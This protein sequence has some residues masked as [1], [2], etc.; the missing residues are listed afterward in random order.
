MADPLVKDLGDVGQD[1]T[2]KDPTKKYDAQ[3]GTYMNPVE[4]IPDADKWQESQMPK[5]PDPS[6]FKLGPLSSGGR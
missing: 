1:A 4:K 3:H 6:P 5:G 2:Y